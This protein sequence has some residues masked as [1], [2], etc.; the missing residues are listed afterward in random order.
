MPTHIIA[1]RC[2][3]PARP[4]PRPAAGWA[5]PACSCS[6]ECAAPLSKRQTCGHSRGKGPFESEREGESRREGIEKRRG[7][8][9]GHHTIKGSV[10]YTSCRIFSP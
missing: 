5:W 1:G 2:W 8:I 4:R 7:W 10:H 9:Q 6:A 3:R